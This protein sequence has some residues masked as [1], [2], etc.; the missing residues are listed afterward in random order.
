MS[1]THPHG[2]VELQALRVS[3]LAPFQL[4]RTN[5]HEQVVRAISRLCVVG[6]RGGIA[7]YALGGELLWGDFYGRRRLC[8]QG[9][10]TWLLGKERHRVYTDRLLHNRLGQPGRVFLL[11]VAHRDPRCY[12]ERQRQLWFLHHTEHVDQRPNTFSTLCWAWAQDHKTE[13]RDRAVPTLT[14]QR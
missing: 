12:L 14:H 7:V 11:T 9:G 8:Y 2:P 4:N 6:P 3:D 10:P 1:Y 13:L 5:P